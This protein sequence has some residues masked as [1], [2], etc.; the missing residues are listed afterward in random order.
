M[1]DSKIMDQVGDSKSDIGTPHPPHDELQG[2]FG[3][4]RLNEAVMT[5]RKCD[6]N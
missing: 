1:V 6:N 5:L 2:S 3:K 4:E